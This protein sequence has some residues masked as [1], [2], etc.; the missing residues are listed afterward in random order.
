MDSLLA[1]RPLLGYPGARVE[2]HEIVC[3]REYRVEIHDPVGCEV[4]KPVTKQDAADMYFHPF[5]FGYEYCAERIE[6]F[7]DGA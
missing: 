1:E 5:V 7:E 2:L 6:T 4:W 3:D